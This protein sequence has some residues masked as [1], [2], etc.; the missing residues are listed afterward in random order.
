MLR[1][2]IDCDN[3]NDAPLLNAHIQEAI[4]KSITEEESDAH[5]ITSDAQN[6]TADTFIQTPNTQR[7]NVNTI[8]TSEKLDKSDELAETLKYLTINDAEYYV[9]D[10]A[11]AN[12]TKGD[13]TSDLKT[14]THTSDGKKRKVT[15][16]RN[17]I[18][19]KNY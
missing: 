15:D 14:V 11:N 1:T 10:S 12:D 19:S 16:I 2:I 4:H 9:S 7:N 8:L 5:N 3:R 18:C 6:V 17:G 13:L